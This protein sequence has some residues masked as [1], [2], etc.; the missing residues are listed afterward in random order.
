MLDGLA[1][2]ARSL[3]PD[4]R[5][6]VLESLGV[7]I[8]G[9]D[10]ELDAA[11]DSLIGLSDG[12][13][14]LAEAVAGGNTAAIVAATAAAADDLAAAAGRLSGLDLAGADATELF[15]GALATIGSR[16]LEHV[17][18]RMQADHVPL[19]DAV[20]RLAGLVDA[21]TFTQEITDE[22]YEEPIAY[23]VDVVRTDRLGMLADP[24]DLLVERTG[25]GQGGSV[26]PLLNDVRL[27]LR[28]AGLVAN[29]VENDQGGVDLV[30]GFGR[31]E[32]PLPATVTVTTTESGLSIVAATDVD[33]DTSVVLGEHT[34][35]SFD[36]P[37]VPPVTVVLEPGQPIHV[38]G[39][40]GSARAG[41]S[42]VWSDPSGRLTLFAPVSC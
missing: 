32:E 29:M 40:T 17:L 10:A 31:A 21:E 20:A 14:A 1:D 3:D 39:L 37:D 41:V 24:A 18:L 25:W 34:T 15:P 42:I 8:S 16:L 23:T 6:R 27:L 2:V 35:M 4:R 19:L 30:L 9:A 5:S 13:A 11:I 22:D 7:S 12:A 36:V 28:R 33:A 38:E 26:A